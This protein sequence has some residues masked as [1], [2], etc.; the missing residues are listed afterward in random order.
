MHRSANSDNQLAFKWR[1]D[2]TGQEYLYVWDR[3][4]GRKKGPGIKMMFNWKIT[5]LEH[6]DEKFEPRFEVE[7]AKAGEYGDRTTFARRGRW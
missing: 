1:Q 2:G 7:L 6:T 5:S 4:G 3:T